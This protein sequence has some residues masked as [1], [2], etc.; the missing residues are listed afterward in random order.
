M[1]IKSP[2]SELVVHW[3]VR[4]YDICE[5]VFICLR[6]QI[7]LILNTLLSEVEPLLNAWHSQPHIEACT[8]GYSISCFDVLSVNAFRIFIT[9]C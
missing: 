4:S 3:D 5:N 6:I 7:T 1:E 8:V 9:S 2:Q